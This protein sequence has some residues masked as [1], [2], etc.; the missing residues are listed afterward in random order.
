MQLVFCSLKLQ[1]NTFKNSFCASQDGGEWVMNQEGPQV[2]NI[3]TGFTWERNPEPCKSWGHTASLPLI[4]TG[5][6]PCRE[7]Q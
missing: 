2:L 1:Q 4:F 3:V 6:P 5:A 7:R